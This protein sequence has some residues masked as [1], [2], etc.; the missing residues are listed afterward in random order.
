MTSRFGVRTALIAVAT[1][2][3]AA[4]PAAAS[5]NRLR[6]RVVPGG[7][8]TPALA[9]AQQIVLPGDAEAAGLRADART[10]L[11]SARPGGDAAA[12]A[13]R[14]GARSIGSRQVGAFLVTR[15]N[16]RALAGALRTRGLLVSASPNVL[17]HRFQAAPAPDPL[18]PQQWWRNAVV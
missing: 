6:P 4:T 10:W 5:P 8:G 9:A 7:A 18:T 16:A 17:R 3:L 2:A 14:L 1:M 12:I 11:V 13:R 15:A